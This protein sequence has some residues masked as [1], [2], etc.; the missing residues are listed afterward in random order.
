ME[1]Q[2]VETYL[3]ERSKNISYWA[4][5]AGV[6]VW[7]M[8]WFKLRSGKETETLWV[9]SLQKK[10]S[11][12]CHYALYPWLIQYHMNPQSCPELE[13]RMF[14]E[15]CTLNLKIDTYNDVEPEWWLIQIMFFK[16]TS[17]IWQLLISSFNSAVIICVHYLYQQL[18]TCS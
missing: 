9:V 14:L 16:C 2:E 17:H 11:M 18:N 12:F 8:I 3:A 15:F 1:K 13:K 5:W 7:N 10:R 6:G 4:Y